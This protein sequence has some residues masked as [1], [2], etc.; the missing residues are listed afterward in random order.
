MTICSLSSSESLDRV[1]VQFATSAKHFA[2]A[3]SVEN[4]ALWRWSNLNVNLELVPYFCVYPF[5][6]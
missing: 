1:L 5:L 3:I 6:F 2:S 4:I